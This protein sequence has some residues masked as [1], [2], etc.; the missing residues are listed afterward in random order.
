M[1]LNVLSC[2]KSKVALTSTCEDFCPNGMFNNSGVCVFGCPKY[3][4]VGPAQTSGKTCCDACPASWYL[5]GRECVKTCSEH[6]EKRGLT[7]L[8]VPC[9]KD[10]GFGVNLN[11]KC[12][13]D[14]DSSALYKFL[15]AD[16]TKCVSA[17]LSESEY[18][19]QPFIY[20]SNTR[21]C[22]ES[23]TCPLYVT[24]KRA[25]VCVKECPDK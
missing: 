23:N 17:C 10:A 15:S 5:S 25:M 2:G 1:C 8:C 14:C 11:G 16:G 24:S 4:L 9:T 7:S 22:L 3:F 20:D 6:V 12:V 13:A 18:E 19:K 21:Q